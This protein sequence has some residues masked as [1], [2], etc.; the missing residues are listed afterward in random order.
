MRFQEETFDTD[1]ALRR[2]AESQMKISNWLRHWWQRRPRSRDL[3]RRR[4][5][6][7]TEVLEPRVVLTV[8]PTADWFGAVHAPDLGVGQTEPLY[9]KR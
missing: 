5:R 4:L 7:R 2:T 6:R 1:V 8:A 3:E 9:E